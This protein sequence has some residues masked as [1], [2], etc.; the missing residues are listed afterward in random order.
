MQ[1]AGSSMAGRRSLKTSLS[2]KVVNEERDT[3]RCGGPGTVGHQVKRRLWS[4]G[5][6]LQVRRK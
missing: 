4:G 1:R 3:I 2:I 5:Y 6:L